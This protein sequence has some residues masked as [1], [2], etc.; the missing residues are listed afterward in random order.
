MHLKVER[1]NGRGRRMSFEAFH[2]LLP[3]LPLCSSSLL[4]LLVI[5][6]RFS[7]C[8]PPL[9]FTGDLLNALVHMPFAIAPPLIVGLGVR[10]I[11]EKLVLRS[12]PSL[13]N[14]ILTGAWQGILF[15]HALV[16]YPP[17][18]PVVV[19]AGVGLKLFLDLFVWHEDTSRCVS[20]VL[21]IALG[22]LGLD[23]V[24]RSFDEA[25]LPPP[26]GSVPRRRSSSPRAR[27]GEGR[28]SVVRFRHKE[29]VDRY[30][31]SS[32]R[33]RHKDS[34]ENSIITAPSLDVS[35]PS[36]SEV[37]DST[38]ARSAAAANPLQKEI[39]DLRTR[40]SLADTERRRFR[41]EKKWAESQGNKAR[42]EQM[43]WNIKRYTA[44]MESFNR[45]ADLKVIEGER[46]LLD[47]HHTR[48]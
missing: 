29:D 13:L 30:G 48:R 10:I 11:L 35:L 31:S 44:L 32:R 42:A 39:A 37:T 16:Q 47:G 15:Y 9:F 18:L 1:G 43:K 17:E 22:I 14:S 33:L 28:E 34:L 12:P 8:I 26:E 20:S 6:L 5:G 7:S 21:G 23:L 25:A 27:R 24:S 38:R 36:I 46:A 45:E 4:L 19:G 3:A 2:V 40:A 41:E